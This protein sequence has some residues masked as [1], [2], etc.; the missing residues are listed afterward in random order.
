MTKTTIAVGAIIV[1]IL[2]IGAYLIL[3]PV[4]TEESHEVSTQESDSSVQTSASSSAPETSSAHLPI[5]SITSSMKN[6]VFP[7]QKIYTIDDS[8]IF[9]ERNG[10]ASDYSYDHRLFDQNEKQVCS[11]ADS[12]A[13]PQLHCDDAHTDMFNTI[14]KNLDKVDLGLSGHTVVLVHTESSL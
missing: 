4:M 10:A 6:P 12:I 14:I 8:L 13:G 7:I 5:A 2:L 3:H 9:V 1:L 11:Y